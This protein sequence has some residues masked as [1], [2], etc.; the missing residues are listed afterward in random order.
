[1]YNRV[2]IRSVIDQVLTK[3]SRD[4]GNEGQLLEVSNRR[5]RHIPP[6]RGQ[7]STHPGRGSIQG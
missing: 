7:V 1:M 6:D 4:D 2:R 5:P 3:H